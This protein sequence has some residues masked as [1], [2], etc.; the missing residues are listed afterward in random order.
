MARFNALYTVLYNVKFLVIKFINEIGMDILS[1]QT[2]R[3]ISTL[4]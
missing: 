4:F 2:N 1:K 3:F